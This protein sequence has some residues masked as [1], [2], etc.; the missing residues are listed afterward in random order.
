M[1]KIK[2]SVW[3]GWVFSGL[4]SA[5]GGA[6]AQNSIIALNAGYIGNGMTAV[7]IDL[8]QPLD[9]LPHTEFIISSPPR[10]VLEFP[11][12]V[13]GL[14]ESALDFTEGGVRGA[15]IVQS[16][17][18]TRFVVYFSRMFPYNIRINGSSLLIVLQDGAADV[19][20]NRSALRLAGAKRDTGL[21]GKQDMRVAGEENAGRVTEAGTP[22]NRVI[23][24][25]RVQ[26][27]ED[28]FA[29]DLD[30]STIQL[31]LPD[32]D[33]LFSHRHNEYLASSFSGDAAPNMSRPNS[34]SR[35]HT[36]ATTR[37]EVI[38][39]TN[40]RWQIA[41]DSALF[42]PVLRF[43]SKGERFDIKPRRRSIWFGWRETFP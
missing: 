20:V 17:G 9:S 21:E 34:T 38:W 33:W 5:G 43:E 25:Y 36:V 14:G 26:S 16:G 11:D 31:E 32:A 35:S 40:E 41:S 7:K 39:L 24:A 18:R 6:H 10:I 28:L 8:A 19:G 30:R 4:L 23:A 15:N 1:R 27:E 37:N 29:P 3:A 12:T 13:N 42:S 22:E 2:L